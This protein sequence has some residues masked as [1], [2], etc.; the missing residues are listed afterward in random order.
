MDISQKR[1]T[2]TNLSDED[3]REAIG[4]R[5]PTA[6]IVLI[7]ATALLTYRAAGYLNLA[8]VGELPDGAPESWFIPLLGDGL[9]GTAAVVVA[10][11]LWQR[12]TFGVWLA[13]IVFHALALWDTTAA[14]I[15]NVREPWETSPFADVIWFAFGFTFLVSVL[16]VYLL[17]RRDV[18]RYYEVGH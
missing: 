6:V 17:S 14:A 3:Q 9:V 11:L 5:R 18:R 4:I 12:P 1:G 2:V 7:A 8:D 16:C 13:A 15:N 10:I